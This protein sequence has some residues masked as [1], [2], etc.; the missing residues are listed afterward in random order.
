MSIAPLSARLIRLM[1]SAAATMLSIL[2][3]KIGRCPRCMRT[4][5]IS[6]FAVWCA[7]F[8]ARLLWPPPGLPA[9]AIS[10]PI[11]LTT[12]WLAHTITFG[13]RLFT[14]LSNKSATHTRTHQ[15]FDGPTRRNL[16]RVLSTTAAVTI[17]AVFVTLKRPRA[18]NSTPC[19]PCPRNRPYC[20]S[21][22]PRSL[23]PYFDPICIDKTFYCTTSGR[24]YQFDELHLC[25]ADCPGRLYCIQCLVY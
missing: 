19:G 10:A 18:Q 3:R 1:R 21:H 5:F 13:K 23:I 8:A 6:A 4:A 16:I 25:L 15:Q 20:C 24:T 22:S 7:Y 14:L 17:P 9:I 11:G 12:L 2:D